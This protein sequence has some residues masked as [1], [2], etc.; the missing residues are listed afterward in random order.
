[1]TEIL[2][3]APVAN[4]RR[5]DR[6]RWAIL[7]ILCLSVFLIVLDNTIINV[8]LPSLYEELGATTSQ[9]QWIVDAYTLV[10]AG[11]LL[12]AGSLGDRLGRKGALMIGLIAFGSFS[13]PRRLRP[14]P[15]QLIAARGLMGIGAALI[16]PATLA[17]LVNVFTEPLER[18]KA[19][20][21]WS[22]TSGLSVALGPVTGGWLLEHFWWGS[23][24]LVNVPI[25][26]DRHRR[27]SPCSSRPAAT[28][29]PCRFDPV[30]MV[31]SIAAIGVLIWAIIEAPNHG[32]T[33]TESLVAFTVGVAAARRLHPLRAPHHPPDARRRRVRRPRFTAGSGAITVSFFGLFGFI[34]LV[35]QYFQFVR[36]YS[37]LSAGVHTV[38]FAVFTGIAAPSSAAPR[39]EGRHQGGRHRRPAVDGGRVRPQSPTSPSTCRTG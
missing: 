10:F 36:G 21:V 27:S 35:S 28:R 8:A 9:L 39:A 29:T 19:I 5:P 20:A 25:V 14:V 17:I 37:P 32:W 7:A 26:L 33:S 24:L 11:L 34:F 30:G 3:D 1:M 18:A 6:R 31:V 16:F 13:R 15:G 22:A 4:I 12:A 2:A 23:V 38:P